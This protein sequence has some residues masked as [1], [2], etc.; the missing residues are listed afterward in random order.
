[1]PNQ[2]RILARPI[3]TIACLGAA[4]CANG[5]ATDDMCPNGMA[6]H[7]FDGG[8]WPSALVTPRPFA[9]GGKPAVTT[10]VDVPGVSGR[11]V[12]MTLI[13]LL[14]GPASPATAQ[15]STGGQF[16]L[17]EF[18]GTTAV[19]GFGA[20]AANNTS[21]IP[22]TTQL[23]FSIPVF[24]LRIR[25]ADVDYSDPVTG[26]EVVSAST[27]V[28]GWTLSA[29]PGAISTNYTATSS[30]IQ[31]SKPFV[32]CEDWESALCD[33]QL[34]HSS[35]ALSTAAFSYRQTTD[36]GGATAYL[37]QVSFCVPTAASA[38][39]V[40]T[41]NPL[42]LLAMLSGVGALGAG[43]VKRRGRNHQH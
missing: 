33:V 2:R 28:S 43:W 41:L 37:R 35:G 29:A 34:Y 7:T 40:P 38:T 12:S 4:V 31:A 23:R 3:L 13:P 39:A 30:S 11:T 21:N 14:P 25:V 17:F 18:P 26:L 20:R 15:D 19:Y 22:L 16:F 5:Q 27:P 36:V 8:T 24:N 9:N 10:S 6:R 32:G 42:A 1:M